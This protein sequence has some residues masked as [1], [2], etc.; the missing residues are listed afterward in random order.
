MYRIRVAVRYGR[1]GFKAE[2]DQASR[3]ACGNSRGEWR[4]EVDCVGNHFHEQLVTE[5]P[6]HTE[7]QVGGDAAHY[8]VHTNRAGKKCLFWSFRCTGN[9][10]K[11]NAK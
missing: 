5:R 7:Q 2:V 6:R 10:R 4:L 3:F 1:E 9:R 11:E 8:P